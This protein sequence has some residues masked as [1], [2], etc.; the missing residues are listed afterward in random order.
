MFLHVLMVYFFCRF[1]RGEL[2]SRFTEGLKFNKGDITPGTPANPSL[3]RQPPSYQ[4]MHS[5]DSGS[6]KGSDKDVNGN[7]GHVRD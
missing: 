3:V 4:R 6:G 1:M 2:N 5:N 7:T